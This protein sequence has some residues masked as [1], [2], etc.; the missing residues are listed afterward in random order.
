[1]PR[2]CGR[3]ARQVLSRCAR[4]RHVVGGT[5]ALLLEAYTLLYFRRAAGRDYTKYKE[6]LFVSKGAGIGKHAIDKHIN[7]LIHSY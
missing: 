4:E 7:T 3:T 1:M 5:N 2:D 6:S